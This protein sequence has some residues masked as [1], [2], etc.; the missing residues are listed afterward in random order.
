MP[1]LVCLCAFVCVSLLT[2]PPLGEIGKLLGTKWKELDEEEKKVRFHAVLPDVLMF[3][4][5]C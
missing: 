5:L 2:A 3:I 1:A 4:P